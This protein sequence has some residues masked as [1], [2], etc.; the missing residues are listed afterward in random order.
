MVAMFCIGGLL[1]FQSTKYRI[2]YDW[3]VS[4]FTT[5]DTKTAGIRT[6]V[7]FT[8]DNLSLRFSNLPSHR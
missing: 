3:S 2:I 7:F 8:E 1:L 4:F 6:F 5:I